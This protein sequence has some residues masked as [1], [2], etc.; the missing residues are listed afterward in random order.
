MTPAVDCS[1]VAPLRL[2]L[3][4][5][6]LMQAHDFTREEAESSVRAFCSLHDIPLT[7]VGHA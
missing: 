2:D 1:D 4:I 6:T 5:E 3:L 7:E